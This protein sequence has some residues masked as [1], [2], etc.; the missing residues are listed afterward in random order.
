MKKIEDYA[1]AAL[2]IFDRPDAPSAADLRDVYLIGICGTGMGSLAALFAEAGYKVSGSDQ[3]AWPPMSDRL[4]SLGIPVIE[5]YSAS[6]IEVEPGLVIVGNACPPTHPEATEARKRGMAQLSFPAALAH[7]FIRDRKSIVVAGTHGKTSTTGLLI[8]VFR[9]AGRDPG[10]LV[11]GV[12]VGNF[13]SQAVGSGRYFIAEGDEYDSAY[14][15]KRPKFFHYHPF[16]AIVTSIEFDHADIYEDLADYESTFREFA[17]TVDPD[18]NLV[19]WGDDDKVAGLATDAKCSVLTYGFNPGNDLRAVAVEAD[20][21]G[22]R[23]EVIRGG[24]VAGAFKVPF[25][26]DHNILNTLAVI[27]VAIEVGIEA[28]VINTAFGTYT[29]MKRRQEVRGVAGGVTVVDDFAH[30]PTAV[31]ETIKSTRRRWPDRRIIAVFEPRSNSSRR[32]V[33]EALYPDALALADVVFLAAPTLRHNDLVEDFMDI[34]NVEQAVLSLGTP[35][36]IRETPGELL[37]PLAEAVV[38]GDIVLIMSNGAMGG[39]HELLLDA[40]R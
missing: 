35:I 24:E 27:A 37:E 3:A 33:F 39:L 32:K 38:E 11:G 10:Y 34:S 28:D 26:G 2:R 29:G 31:R 16:V 15:D 9:E 17:R 22:T 4:E 12:Q 20:A 23:F 6:N 21:A 14:F 7:Y 1:D 30:H 40:L 5:G 36:V 25:W 8:H 13:E 18:G 19:L